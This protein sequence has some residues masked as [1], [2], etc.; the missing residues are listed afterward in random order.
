MLCRCR[1]RQISWVRAARLQRFEDTPHRI[2]MLHDPKQHQTA[3]THKGH[4]S[5]LEPRILVARDF[6]PARQWFGAPGTRPKRDD[7]EPEAL[8]PNTQTNPPHIQATGV[9][10][11][12]GTDK[13]TFVTIAILQAVTAN[14]RGHGHTPHWQ[15]TTYKN[16]IV[17]CETVSHHRC[18]T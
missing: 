1:L 13:D 8:S 5:S 6:D 2:D 9:G 4:P 18:L 14:S 11:D 3:A 17:L 16:V 15:R 12:M 7:G 10:T